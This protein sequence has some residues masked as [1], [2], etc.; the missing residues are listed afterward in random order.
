MEVMRTRARV[1]MGTQA[2]GD[3]IMRVQAGINAC[4]PMMQ[5]SSLHPLGCWPI[6]WHSHD[7]NTTT[8]S[9]QVLGASLA[10]LASAASC[11]TDCNI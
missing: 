2:H 4:A 11:N 8:A 9:L 1:G 7:N 5:L 10:N 3:H 6:S